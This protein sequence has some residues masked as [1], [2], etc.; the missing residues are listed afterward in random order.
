MPNVH[1][2]AYEDRWRSWWT[3]SIL[4]QG[5]LSSTKLSTVLCIKVHNTFWGSTPKFVCF[6][7][8]HSI[9]NTRIKGW[10]V[11]DRMQDNQHQTCH[12]RQLRT[13]YYAKNHPWHWPY[14]WT[15]HQ[16]SAINTF[17]DWSKSN[18]NPT[19]VWL[20]HAILF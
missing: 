11:D 6:E 9:E 5:S 10:V 19:K 3:K 8:Y 1:I 7:E 15:W 14:T 20:W 2:F 17:S 13:H 12:Q 4:K 18:V 16:G